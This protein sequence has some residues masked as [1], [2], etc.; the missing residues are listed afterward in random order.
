VEFRLLGPL[1]V[2]DGGRPIPL[3]GA[4]QRSVLALLVL[5]RGRPVATDTL[6]ELIWNGAAPETARKSVQG[7]VSA[8]RDALGDGRIQTV[9]RGYA[10]R[11]EPGE[12]DVDHLES[13][14]RA[15]VAT[16]PTKAVDL[17][18]DALRSIRGE[19]LEDL[20]REPWADREAAPLEE[21]TLTAIESRIDAELGL[22]G[23]RSVLPELERLVAR[24]P[25]REQ[26]LER[27]M[28]A[29]YRSGRQADALEAFRRGAARLREDLGLEPS[30]MLQDLEQA[31]LNHDES[32]DAPRTVQ[33]RRAALRRRFG[34][35]LIAVA[36]SM[37]AAAAVA[38]AAVI[39]TGHGDVSYASLKP[40]VVL[41]DMQHN[42]LIKEWPGRYFSYP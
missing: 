8:L 6:I 4:K 26:L 15:S 13:A 33:A 42:R 23:H 1:E 41:L 16:R 27:L 12:I 31:V 25:Y 37:I 40:G 19:P 24:Y 28:L 20:R 22:G 29:L 5:A 18:R 11:V 9:A 3:G 38:A 32:L 10:L 30:R 7:Y 35:K 39:A 14:V 2:V 36:G 17:L 34:W 21:L